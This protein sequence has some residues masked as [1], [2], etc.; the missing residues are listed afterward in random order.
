[1]ES[2]QLKP[3]GIIETPYDEPH[4]IPIQGTFESDEV[5][6]CCVINKE[7]QEGLKDLEH[8]SHAILIY[9][10]HKTNDEKIIAKP[11]LEP[12]EHGIFAIRSPYRPNKIGISIVK[13]KKIVDNNL[14]FTEVDML[15]GTPLLDI[16]PYVKHFDSREKTISGWIDKH[17]EKG[18]IPDQTILNRK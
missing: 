11:F 3:I 18:N 9:F 6:G 8:F 13:I 17:F 1:M 7:L 10:F 16:K 2:I 12:I 5:E 14:F 4:N 15:N